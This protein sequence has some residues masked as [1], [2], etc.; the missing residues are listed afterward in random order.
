[1]KTVKIDVDIPPNRELRLVL[2]ADI[3]TGR[4]TLLLVFDTPAKHAPLD[5][6]VHDIGPWPI[7]DSLRREDLYGDDGR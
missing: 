6:P 5:L 3:P 2:P 4:S 1:M 7:H